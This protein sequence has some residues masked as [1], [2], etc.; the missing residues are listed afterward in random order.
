LALMMRPPRSLPGRALDYTIAASLVLLP[1][2]ISLAK[3]LPCTRATLYWPAGTVIVN[4]LLSSAPIPSGILSGIVGPL[5][6]LPSLQRAK[7]ISR[8]VAQMVAILL[9]LIL[10]PSA[11]LAPLYA[12]MRATSRCLGFL[13]IQA[14][15]GPETW[16]YYA[17]GTAT[18]LAA[19]ISLRT[20]RQVRAA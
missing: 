14:L 6:A 20:Y 19:W 2:A 7:R 18:L 1:A 5:I 16:V 3:A 10:L 15:F 8:R 9:S 4:T 13:G 11:G 12:H 17:S